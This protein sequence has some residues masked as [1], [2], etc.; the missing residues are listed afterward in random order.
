M[1]ATRRNLAGSAALA[2]A[3]GDLM[4]VEVIAE[5]NDYVRELF[6]EDLPA[7]AG[8]GLS[9]LQSSTSRILRAC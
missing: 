8:G 2:R 7:G 4:G 9:P 3:I 5:L 1:A 6:V